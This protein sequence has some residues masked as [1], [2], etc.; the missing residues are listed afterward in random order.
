MMDFGDDSDAFTSIFQDFKPHL[1][2]IN[3]MKDTQ[4]YIT[5]VKEL[6]DLL[7][8]R[9]DKPGLK[10]MIEEDSRFDCLDE[11]TFE[12]ASVL[13]NAPSIWRKRRKYK[14]DEGRTYSM[15]KALRDWE[16]AIVEEKDK[17]IKDKD[18]TI[19]AKDKQLTEKEKQ[20]DKLEKEISKLKAQL[21]ASE[22]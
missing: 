8:N 6:L 19:K 15:C 1:L 11:E 16:A 21:S 18:R 12:T 3:E 14:N 4:S 9:A 7:R 2:K 10:K 17:I 22:V 20:I 13:M 5:E